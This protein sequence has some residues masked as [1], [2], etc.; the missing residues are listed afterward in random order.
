MFYTSTF[1]KYHTA[2]ILKNDIIFMEV[3]IGYEKNKR[4]AKRNGSRRMAYELQAFQC[5]AAG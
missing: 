2:Y 5:F 4:F 3:L 1:I